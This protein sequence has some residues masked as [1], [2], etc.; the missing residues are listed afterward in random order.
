MA[1]SPLRLRRP[2]ARKKNWEKTAEAYI[3]QDKESRWFLSR[4]KNLQPIVRLQWRNSILF[5][6]V[7][8]QVGIHSSKCGSLAQWLT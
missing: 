8:S 4:L 5:F 6:L 3:K 2:R 7:N 1:P